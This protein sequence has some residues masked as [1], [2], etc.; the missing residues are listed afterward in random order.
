MWFGAAG[1]SSAVFQKWSEQLSAALPDSAESEDAGCVLV[2]YFARYPIKAVKLAGAG[3]SASAP[4][5]ALHGRYR[6]YFDNG[7]SVGLRSDGELQLWLDDAGRPHL[8]G[9]L[10]V[11]EYVARVLE[12]EGGSEQ[13][14]AA[15]ALAI[16]ARS[17]L[18]QNAAR[19]EGCQRIADSSGAQRV[20]ASPAGAPAR[21]IARWTDQLVVA[22][23]TVRYH[24]TTPGTNVL[25]WRDALA[26]AGR[27]DYFDAILAK[28]YPQGELTTMNSSG[29]RCVRLA[30]AEAWLA[31]QLP[32]WER[33]L[34]GEA[35]YER[36]N[37]MPAVCELGAGAPYSEQSRNRIFVRGLATRED[38]IT[39][40]HEFLHLGLRNH[41][42]GQDEAAVE[43]LARRLTDLK[44]EKL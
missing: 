27:G 37:D 18:Q 30:A 10:G 15:K 38:R 16:A 11:N 33:L 5:G 42:R 4:P 23:V 29:V 9:R 8:R 25:S 7:N 20:G 14:E 1:S 32:D 2:D 40:A 22:G 36:P 3:V 41:P 26:Q 31:R 17:Y 28:A 39:L 43:R 21:A 44:L 35:G 6:V 34:R 19:A 12:R 13:A 24:T